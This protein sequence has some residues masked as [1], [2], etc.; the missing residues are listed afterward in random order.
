MHRAEPVAEKLDD[1]F[2]L[3]KRCGPRR[4]KR[5]I[6]WTWEIRRRSEPFGVKYDGD[7]FTTPQEAKLAGEKALKELLHNLALVT[8][9]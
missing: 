2:V 8:P 1:Y 9:H 7:D 6:R 3:I 5:R 4:V